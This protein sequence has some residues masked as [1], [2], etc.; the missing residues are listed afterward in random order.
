ML[1]E[2]LSDKSGKQKTNKIDF[3]NK[4]LTKFQNNHA[5]FDQLI[6][7]YRLSFKEKLGDIQN[8]MEQQDWAKITSVMHKL[9]GSAGS[10]GFQQLSDFAILV[11]EH[12]RQGDLL[13]AKRYIVDMQECMQKLYSETEQHTLIKA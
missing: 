7:N 11:E 8:A 12:I 5:E 10:Y 2:Y 6:K 4:S 3:D 9:K 1:V 13:Q